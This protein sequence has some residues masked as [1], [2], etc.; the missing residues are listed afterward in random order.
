MPKNKLKFKYWDK[1]RSVNGLLC[2]SNALWLSLQSL[3]PKYFSNYT[4]KN[5]KT[6]DY[7]FFS[8]NQHNIHK[9]TG[10]PWI[11]YSFVYLTGIPW[12]VYSFVYLTGAA[13]MVESFKYLT[14]TP[15]M[16][17]SF[18]YL[19]GAAWMVDGLREIIDLPS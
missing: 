10:I 5:Y 7:Y 6:L 9:S 1:V 12:I 3:G 4:K 11:V 8:S 17:D 2:W 18:V 16:V 14:G 15:R 13:W 19:T